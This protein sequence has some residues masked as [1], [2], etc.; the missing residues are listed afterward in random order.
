MEPVAWLLLLTGLALA[1]NLAVTV[2][3]AM[4]RAVGEHRQA[5]ALR[6]IEEETPPGAGN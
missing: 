2:G 4:A 1:L 6:E 5:R 3:L